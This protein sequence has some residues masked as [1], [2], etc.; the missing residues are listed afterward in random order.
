MIDDS[1]SQ[2]HR[3]GSVMDGGEGERRPRTLAEKILSRAAGQPAVAGDL[4]V[5]EVGMAMTHDSLVQSVIRAMQAMGAERVYDPERVALFV[6]H[7]APASTLQV[8]EAQATLRRFAREQGIRRF[9]DAGRGI[10][11]QVMIEERLVM[12]GTVVVGADSHSNLYGCVAAF[13]TGMGSTDVAVAMATGQTWLRVPS[14][15]RIDVSGALPPGV[16]AKDLSLQLEGR[17][18]AAGARYMAVEFSLPETLDMPARMTLCGMTTE[19]GAKAG[20][21]VPDAVSATYAPMPDWLYP[22]PDA[23]YERRLEVDLSTLEPLVAEPGHVDRVTPVSATGNVP[24]DV[25]FIGTCTNGRLADLRAAAQVLRG[26]R[27]HSGTRMMVVPASHEVLSAAAADGTLSI[28]LEAGATL[29]TPGCGPCMGR[30]MGALS[31]GEVCLSTGNRNFAGRM[32]SAEARIYLGS[33]EV[34]AA[35]A[36]AGRIAAPSELVVSG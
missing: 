32:G 15:I 8:A 1:A 26:R 36:V 30:H 4:V 35:S 24:V 11:H 21:V 14:T 13:G 19:L 7:V 34:A 3:T 28:L 2:A 22:D 12:P 31:A 10:C 20:L 23:V 27:V 25:V 33:P 29:G 9:Y 16:G 17:L 18:G 6:D 5:V